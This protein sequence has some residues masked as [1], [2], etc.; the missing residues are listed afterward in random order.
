MTL[1]ELMEDLDRLAWRAQID[2]EATERGAPSEEDAIAAEL[3]RIA[4]SITV[5]VLDALEHN[6][7]H[8]AWVLRLS[9]H[10]RGDDPVVRARRLVH[11]RSSEV[12]HLAGQLLGQP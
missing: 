9:P 6:G 12:R 10:V 2:F 7:S 5:P 8:P 11:D 1:E 3:R 4:G